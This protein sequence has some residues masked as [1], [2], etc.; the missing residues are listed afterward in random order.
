VAAVDHLAAHL[1][2]AP[3]DLMA[4]LGISGRT[5]QRR[6]QQGVLS[7]DESDR[8]YRVARLFQR[9]TDVFGAEDNAVDWL[10]RQKP[11]FEFHAPLEL[12]GSDAGAQAVEQELGRIE[13][14]D[15]T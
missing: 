5:S 9:A 12:L 4:L 1:G 2:V 7:A 6:R 8:L 10:K 3:D 15:F 13:Y 11:F 14:G